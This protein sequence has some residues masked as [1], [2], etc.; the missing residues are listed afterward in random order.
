[1][2]SCFVTTHWTRV[3]ASRGNSPEARQALS[4]LCGAYYAPVVAFLRQSGSDEDAARDLA[5][6]FFVNLLERH[7]LDGADPERGRF[8]TY[9]LGAVKHF[10]AKHRAFASRQKRGGGAVHQPIGQGS[11]TSPGLEIPDR[12]VL[13]P[14][15]LFDR[16]WAL[17]VLRRALDQ[18]A[19]D[20]EEN[21]TVCQFEALKPWLG[22]TRP[23]LSQEEAA[24]QLDMSDGTVRVAIHR[25]RR[26]FR[27]LVKAE[28]AETVAD[29]SELEA[30]LRYLVS[31]LA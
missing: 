18:L 24:R 8:R 1:M 21:G 4:D 20:S 25:L 22:G 7:G 26:R 15:A 9:L 29:A 3:V 14:D 5:H 30:E 17:N 28:I 13:P 6:E 19:R 31:V 12:T 2:S 10:L 23:D 27:A 11:D 16:E